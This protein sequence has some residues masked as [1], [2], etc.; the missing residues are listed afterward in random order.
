MEI[1]P[2]SVGGRASFDKGSGVKALDQRKYH[3]KNENHEKL[4]KV[5]WIYLKIAYRTCPD[6]CRL[7]GPTFHE[8]D[9]G[10]LFLFQKYAQYALVRRKQHPPQ[11]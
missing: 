10:K 8:H 7:R 4:M 1:F 6:Y 5:V 2:R 11:F 9:R 3:E